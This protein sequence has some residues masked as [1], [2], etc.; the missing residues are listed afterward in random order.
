MNHHIIEIV[1][2]CRDNGE[3][4]VLAVSDFLAE[5]G[6][7]PSRDFIERVL[8]PRAEERILQDERKCAPDNLAR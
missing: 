1:K 4:P 5:K 8:I 2:Y 7:H 3:S 6:D